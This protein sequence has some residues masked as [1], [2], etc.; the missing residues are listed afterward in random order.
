VRRLGQA[1]DIAPTVALL[2]SEHGGWITGQVISVSG[3]FSMV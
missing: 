3:G 1:T 2:A